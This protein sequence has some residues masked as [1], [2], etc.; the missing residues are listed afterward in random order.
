MGFLKES[1][2]FSGDTSLILS[3]ETLATY[4]GKRRLLDPNLSDL[5]KIY[6][7]RGHYIKTRPEISTHWFAAVFSNAMSHRLW[8]CRHNCYTREGRS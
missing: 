8:K 2:S 4:P 3:K 6:K 5:E 1:S 7:V